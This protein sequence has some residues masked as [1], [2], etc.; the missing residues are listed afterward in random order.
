[1]A[2][3]LTCPACTA[4]FALAEDVR[5]KKAFCPKCGAALIISKAGV[6][7]GLGPP[8]TTAPAPAS[9]AWKTNRLRLLVALALLLLVGGTIGY[10]LSGGQAQHEVANN[11][12]DQPPASAHE[13][14]DDQP[15]EQPHKEPEKPADKAAKQPPD[16]HVPPAASS[17]TGDQLAHLVEN[18]TVLPGKALPG[19]PFTHRL[20]IVEGAR[21]EL[22]PG[23]QPTGLALTPEGLLTWTPL[24]GQH[25]A[26]Y[27]VRLRTNPGALVRTVKI[28][29]E[30]DPETTLALTGIGGWVMH[31]DGVTLIVAL[32]D[33]AELVYIDTIANKVVKR[34]EAPFKPN[35]LAAQ[36]R[37]LFVSAQSA[38]ELHVLELDTGRKLKTVK[39]PGSFLTDMV[40]HPDRG[41]VYA[42]ESGYPAIV[43]I[44]PFT[45]TVARAKVVAFNPRGVGADALAQAMFVEPRTRR[46]F[47]NDVRG[48]SLAVDPSNPDVLYTIW[49]TAIPMGGDMIQDSTFLSKFTVTGRDFEAMFAD[50][51]VSAPG[52]PRER[53]V[54]RVNGDGSRIGVIAG[55]R[56]GSGNTEGISLFDAVGPTGIADC[57]PSPG[58][59]AFHPVLDL[60]AA[61]QDYVLSPSL[62]GRHERQ[63]VLH[64]FNCKSLIETKITFSAEPAANKLKPARG[65]LTFGARGTKLLFYDWAQGCLRLLPLPL[66]DKEKE[67]L[68]RA[69]PVP[70]GEK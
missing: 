2:I 68:A 26:T 62:G 59:L 11:G 22:L 43:A 5:G 30:A 31:P 14:P 6:A 57:G 3:K 20:P 48:V 9:P 55:A 7:K 63:T 8:V 44:D 35:L 51:C 18:N 52:N 65:L 27:E 15:H 33:Q 19:K 1:M 64:L 47:I 54:V 23:L 37:N 41:L 61:E 50:S 39:L 67:A 28:V 42:T 40:C 25:P 49:R 24:P 10:L 36:G 32:P 46:H 12:R 70:R 38:S 17:R 16:H 53:V 56:S 69:Y 21:F 29:L 60:A 13:G 4:L 45:E 66:T 34:V 58:D